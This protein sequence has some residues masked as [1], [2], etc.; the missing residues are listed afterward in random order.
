MLVLTLRPAGLS[1]F[2]WVERPAEVG[3][4]EIVA[5]ESLV[6]DVLH[7]RKAF[8][9]ECLCIVSIVSA[10]LQHLLRGIKFLTE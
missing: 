4:M 5:T 9:N 10:I 2:S 3:A 6:D 1:R 7:T 8:Y